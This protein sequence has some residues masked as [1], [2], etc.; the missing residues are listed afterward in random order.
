MNQLR[1]QIAQLTLALQDAY[2][3]I[4]N[5]IANHIFRRLGLR[6]YF[7]QPVSQFQFMSQFDESIDQYNELNF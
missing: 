2:T 5:D 7:I 6:Y 3:C 1:N 4:H